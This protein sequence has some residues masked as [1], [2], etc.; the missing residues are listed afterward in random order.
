MSNDIRLLFEL[1]EDQYIQLLMSL[2]RIWMLLF[3][4]GLCTFFFFLFSDINYF[5][6]VIENWISTVKVKSQVKPNFLPDEP[7][8]STSKSMTSNEAQMLKNSSTDE[9]EPSK[10]GNVMTYDLVQAIDQ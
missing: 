4:Q 2:L 9:P 1:V 10:D 6:S 5:I 8:P 3:T 7:Q